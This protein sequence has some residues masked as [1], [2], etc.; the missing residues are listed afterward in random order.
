MIQILTLIAS[1]LFAAP[2]DRPNVVFILAD[3]LGYGDLGCYGAPDIRTPHLDKLAEQGVRLTDA[4]ANSMVCTPTRCAL[5]TGRYQ[6]RIGGLEWA[7]YPEAK[8]HGLP[9]EE[10]SLARLLKDVGYVTAMSGKWHL[11]NN[12]ERA[13]NVHGFDRFFGLLGGNHDYFTHKDR[14]DRH[15][16]FIDKKNTV[17]PG[18]STELI[19]EYALRFLSEIKDDRFFLYVAYNAPHWP[20]QGPDDAKVTIDETNWSQGTRET[21]IEMVESMDAGIGELLSELNR[22]ELS[23][24]T[25]VIF[26]SD[27]GGDRNSRNT[28]LN[29]F[30]TTIWEGGIRVPGIV[31]WPGKVPAG[32]VSHQPC[33]TMDFTASILQLAGAKPP[34]DRP[35]DGIDILPILAGKQPQQK[36]TLFWRRTTVRG[37]RTHR[38]VRDGDFKYIDEYGK[39]EYLYNLKEDIGEQINMAE[40]LPKKAATMKSKLDAW[41]ARISPPLYPEMSDN[42]LGP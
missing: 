17:M 6:Q 38:A 4:Y 14:N 7:I 30:K 15:D 22:L 20:F 18:Y 8:L 32:T 16:L 33:I 3:D 1:L 23:K 25:L 5:M 36:R 34:A 13:P 42:Q 35:L 37:E 9:T 27:N 29:N 10:Q 19:T 41:E 11:G 12:V 31:R 21:Y 24:D 2:D 40:G 26:M 28:P 39:A